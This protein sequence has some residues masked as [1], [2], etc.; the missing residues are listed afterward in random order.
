MLNARKQTCKFK[1]VDVFSIW[2]H[3]L[4][5]FVRNNPHLRFVVIWFGAGHFS[6]LTATLALL[7][8]P[9]AAQQ[10]TRKELFLEH[11]D[12]KN[13]CDQTELGE[14]CCG[15][16]TGRTKQNA[17]PRGL[18][19]VVS[20]CRCWY[21]K[22]TAVCTSAPSDPSDPRSGGIYAWLHCYRQQVRC[23]TLAAAVLS[24]NPTRSPSNTTHATMPL[25]M[26]CAAAVLS[27]V[28]EHARDAS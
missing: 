24:V 12:Q 19:A 21:A 8:P 27:A 20:L 18:C 26:D 2:G 17:A 23:S 16:S 15:G 11:A 3:R 1:K 5:Y 28:L 22:H 25:C 7:A 13:V 14:A 9:T 4:S 6:S 10:H